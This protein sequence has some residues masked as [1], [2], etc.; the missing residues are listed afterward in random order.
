M[1]DWDDLRFILAVDRQGSAMAAAQALGVNASTV[2]RR[3]TRFEDR[4]GVRLFERR[5]SGFKST[6]ECVAL[7]QAAADIED[8]VTAIS[9][10]I[11]G[12]DFRLEGRLKVTT[13]D[14]FMNAQMAGHLASFSM[15]HPQIRLELT[16]T[17]NRLDLSR[18]DADIA[19]R[20][21]NN[22]PENLVGQRV[23]RFVSGLYGNSDHAARLGPGTSLDVLKREPW[24]GLGEALGNS[25]L[26]QWLNRNLDDAQMAIRVDTFSAVC[27]SIEA[28]MGIGMLPCLVG[29][30]NANLH[31]LA[32]PVRETGIDLW[33]LTHPEIRSAAKVRAFMD[34]ITTAMRR[35]QDR[36]DG[37]LP[38]GAIGKDVEPPPPATAKTKPEIE[39]ET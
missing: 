19:I 29:D 27:A 39:N 7:V 9:R 15:L 28:G 24:I 10:E 36:F 22:P 33:V 16:L 34:F 6:P 37:T 11:L 32:P 35:Q 31:R 21:S 30:A 13:T 8:R 2:Q 38:V 14:T 3:I 23:A 18:Q 25:P 1:I 12:R 5:Q 26:G 4:H 17:N 20:P